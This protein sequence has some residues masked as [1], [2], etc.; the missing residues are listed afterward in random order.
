VLE[1]LLD[2]GI[3]G[4]MM[5]SANQQKRPFETQADLIEQLLATTFADATPARLAECRAKLKEKKP[6]LKTAR[7]RRDAAHAALAHAGELKSCRRDQRAQEGQLKQ[8]QEEVAAAEAFA[9]SGDAELQRM[10][11]AVSAA[12]GELQAIAYDG[13]LHKQ[14]IAA[15]STARQLEGLAADADAALRAAADTSA[16]AAATTQLT[17]ASA[18][19]EDAKA[20][21]TEAKRAV[22][23]AQRAHAAAHLR[24]GLRKGDA[25]P[26]CNATVG[27]L[28]AG[29][30]PALD[31]VERAA[32]KATGAEEKA[33]KAFDAARQRLA[34]EQQKAEQA[35][36][37]AASATKRVVGTKKELTK[38]LPKEFS[39]DAAAI[40]AKVSELEGLGRKAE[41]LRKQCD[42]LR[43]ECATYERKVAAA[44]AE[45]AALQAAATTHAAAA[46]EQRRKGDE[47]IAQLQEIV[48]RWK[49]DDIADAMAAKTD[50][51]PAL[52]SMHADAQRECDALE[53]A[54]GGLE[55]DEKRIERDIAQAAEQR[56]KLEQLRRDAALYGALADLLQ[57]NKFREWFLGEAMLLLAHAA[58]TRLET[59]DPDR[60]YGLDVAGGEFVVVDHWQADAAR[61]PE[62]LSGGETFV[63]SLALALALAEQLP[64][65]QTA[66]AGA[67]ESLFLDEGF[68]TLDTHTLDPVMSALDELRAEDRLV[69]IITHVPELAQRIETR[70][71]IDK[72]PQGSTLRVVG[73]AA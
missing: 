28:P 34:L 58:S 64:R 22:E 32:A 59:L 69:G 9:A 50:P 23:E 5:M 40:A 18:H 67:L 72:S 15:R 43:E 4:R 73:S 30:A 71:E 21:S 41:A 29:T 38:Q 3:Y 53:R 61:S 54:I 57:A 25:C 51:K 39:G 36:A 24:R 49:W 8:K 35:A 19:H 52:A 27:A 60:R 11:G 62:T 14:L 46:D 63:A 42:V 44:A 55:Q 7:Q 48:Q 2:V 47:A 12:E 65:I 13:E 66:A 33:S 70:I 45:L 1:E 68:G 37:N 20:A 16:V 56:C 6:A 31:A 17:Q 26:V 10:R